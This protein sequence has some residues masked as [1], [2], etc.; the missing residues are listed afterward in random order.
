MG[1]LENVLNFKRQVL[2][3]RVY[4][5]EFMIGKM[6]EIGLSYCRN[7]GL[8]S[9]NLS[10]IKQL[11]YYFM[12]D[13]KFKGDLTKGILLR[14]N[15]GTGKTLM[16]RIFSEKKPGFNFTGP[17]NFLFHSVIDV[18]AK[19]INHGHEGL[20]EYSKFYL[21]DEMLKNWTNTICFDELGI[22]PTTAMNYGNKLNIMELIITKRY[23]NWQSYGQLTHFTTNLTPDEI[24]KN[25]GERIRSRI[26]EMCNDL[27]LLGEDKRMK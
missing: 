11:L 23:N 2:P 1:N 18:Y 5:E 12:E 4:K 8:D 26:A 20:D 3:V 9:F 22:E 21:H 15:I 10:T 7:F 25:Y 13:S 14:G 17:K 27:V 6:N 16:M 19:F 24:E